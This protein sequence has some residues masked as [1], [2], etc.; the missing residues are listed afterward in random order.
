MSSSVVLKK[1]G[2]FSV[3]EFHF[4][5]FPTNMFACSHLVANFGNFVRVRRGQRRRTFPLALP[6]WRA[7][8]LAVGHNLGKVE[9]HVLWGGASWSESSLIGMIRVVIEVMLKKELNKF[10][11][12]TV[13]GAQIFGPDVWRSIWWKHWLLI[14]NRIFCCF[15]DGQQTQKQNLPILWWFSSCSQDF[16][17]PKIRKKRVNSA[18]A[19]ENAAKT[20]W[21]LGQAARWCLSIQALG[22]ILGLWG[23]GVGAK[24]VFWIQRMNDGMDLVERVNYGKII[25]FF[26]FAIF[27]REPFLRVFWLNLL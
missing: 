11:P 20:R 12:R 9:S 2:Y 1:P 19:V 7:T 27:W 10:L 13:R 8:L 5:N 21:K 4:M 24:F 23:L 17:G 15:S 3:S 14:F 6:I 16:L 26:A 22:C 25:F 18:A